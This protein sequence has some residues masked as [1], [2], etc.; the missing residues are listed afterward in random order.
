MT[1]TMLTINN[2]KFGVSL[3]LQIS[4]MLL[5]TKVTKSVFELSTLV[6][7]FLGE[8]DIGHTRKVDVVR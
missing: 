7:E 8:I 5:T 1:S 2:A 6:A 4:T 3:C